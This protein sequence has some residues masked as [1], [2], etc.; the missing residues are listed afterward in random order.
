[1]K[2]LADVKKELKAMKK[3]K[4]LT[5]NRI[6]VTVMEA[7]EENEMHQ[8]CVNVW[9]YDRWH[10][11]EFEDYITGEQETLSKA[12]GLGKR[13]ATSFTSAGYK[14]KYNGVENC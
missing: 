10:N 7:E 6:S 2:T 12:E 9:L 1:M 14:A 5:V 8:V 3:N 13:H 4:G 11:E